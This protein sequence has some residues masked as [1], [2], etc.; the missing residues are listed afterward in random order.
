[1]AYNTPK[2]GS[3]QSNIVTSANAVTM[4]NGVATNI[5]S[6]TLTP[7]NYILSG[8]VVFS[9]A[10][11]VVGTQRISISNTSGSVGTVGDNSIIGLISS[12]NLSGSDVTLS[13][14]AYMVQVD[15][16]TTFYLV[17]QISYTLGT[18]KAYGKLSSF[19]LP[20]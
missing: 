13:L 3:I 7:G 15:T 8:T 18:A 11:T 20:A 17:G 2:L 6:V 19:Q 10:I 5:T 9:G 14:P 1:M 16:T 4:P 12:L